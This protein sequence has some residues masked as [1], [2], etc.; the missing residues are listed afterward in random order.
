MGGGIWRRGR[1]GREVGLLLHDWRR[2]RSG[3]Q[4]WALA[5][6][7]AAVRAGVQAGAARLM[8]QVLHWRLLQDGGALL[9]KGRT[10]LLLLMVLRNYNV[11]RPSVHLGAHRT[12][13]PT[14]VHYELLARAGRKEAFLLVRTLGADHHSLGRADYAA[15]RSAHVLDLD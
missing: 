7:T 14:A 1:S 3:R 2:L 6:G 8:D 4:G 10:C 13:L 15:A 5:R 9:H 11:N 12:D